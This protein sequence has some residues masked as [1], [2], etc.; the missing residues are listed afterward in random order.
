M[1]YWCD[2]NKAKFTNERRRWLF[3]WFVEPHIMKT[4]LTNLLTIQNYVVDFQ[5][6]GLVV[7]SVPLVGNFAFNYL[8]LTLCVENNRDISCHK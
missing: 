1:T 4:L 3:E 7:G 5:I 8:L 2:Q 6:S